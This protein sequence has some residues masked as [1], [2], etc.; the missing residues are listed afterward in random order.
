MYFILKTSVF[1]G[2]S[3]RLGL[4]FN[5]NWFMVGVH[6]SSHRGIQ[7]VA[8]NERSVRDRL[9]SLGNSQLHP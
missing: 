5:N 6:L 9:L 2:G 1:R 7:E 3:Y 8:K 4:T